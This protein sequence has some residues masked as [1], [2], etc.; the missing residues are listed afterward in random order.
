MRPDVQPAHSFNEVTN[1]ARARA[2]QMIQGEPC[3]T[4]TKR[5]VK[6]T[7]RSCSSESKFLRVAALENPI[8]GRFTDQPG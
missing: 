4:G 6:I 7:R 2:L 3:V 5:K 8:S 1:V